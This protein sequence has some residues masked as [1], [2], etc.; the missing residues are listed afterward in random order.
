MKFK[1]DATTI[2]YKVAMHFSS[3]PLSEMIYVHTYLKKKW[4]MST[5]QKIEMIYV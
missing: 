1:G 4:F 3:H 5:Y 2:V